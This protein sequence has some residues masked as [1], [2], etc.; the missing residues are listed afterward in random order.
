[1]RTRRRILALSLASLLG[2][3]ACKDSTGS[4]GSKDNPSGTLSFSYAGSST[5]TFSATGAFPKTRG[6]PTVQFAAAIRDTVAGE[7]IMVLVGFQPTA[8][9]RGHL[10]EFDF[11]NIATAQTLTLDEACYSHQTL[12]GCAL[13]LVGLNYDLSTVAG[14]ASY[15]FDSG[16]FT[17]TSVSATGVRGTFTGHATDPDTGHTIDVTGGQFDVPFVRP[18]SS[19]LDRAIVD[20]PSLLRARR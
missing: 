18:A 9:G 4:G 19:G 12:A 14:E 17:V 11:A 6:V 8:G 3:A 16:S 2:V 1:M 20:R 10:V 7:P 5:G 15:L 13:A